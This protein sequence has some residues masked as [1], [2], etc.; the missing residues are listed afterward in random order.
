MSA[1]GLIP[2][3]LEERAR[4]FGLGL[5]I[6][7]QHFAAVFAPVGAGRILAETFGADIHG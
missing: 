3:F 7:Q 2:V 4:L 5:G 1:R 6:R